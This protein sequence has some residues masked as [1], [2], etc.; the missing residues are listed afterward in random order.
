MRP[1]RKK[2]LDEL[3]FEWKADGAFRNFKPDD[4]LWHQQY[5]KLLEYKRI[6]G[7][8]KVPIR[9]E[10]HKSLGKWVS[11]QRTYHKDCKLRQD[12]K[13]L[14][15]EIDFAWKANTVATRHSTTD[16]RGLAI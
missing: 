14:L 3:G 4:K 13:E 8:C 11:T 16:V 10:Q 9:Y 7:N 2:F 6:N 12:R 1:D 5:E 15:E